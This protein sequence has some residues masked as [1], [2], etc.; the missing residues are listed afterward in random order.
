MSVRK[1]T[2]KARKRE[3]KLKLLRST[4]FAI[5]GT[6]NGGNIDIPSRII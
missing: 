2:N 3:R 4:E 5:N 6:Q 1:F